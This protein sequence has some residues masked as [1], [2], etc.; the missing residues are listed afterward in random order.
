MNRQELF[1]KAV[2]GILKQGGPSVDSDCMNGCVYR[3]PHGL[4]CA[5]GHLIEDETLLEETCGISNLLL[6]RPAVREALGVEGTDDE[7]FLCDLQSCHDM[8]SGIAQ[9][10]EYIRRFRDHATAFAVRYG[11]DRSVLG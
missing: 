3:G 10:E 1:D 2:T 8:P 9:P 6:R 5:I 11:L 4:R 7:R